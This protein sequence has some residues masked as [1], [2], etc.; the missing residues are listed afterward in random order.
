MFVDETS[1]SSSKLG[2]T[3]GRVNHR[4]VPPI[5][6]DELLAGNSL[7]TTSKR[8]LVTMSKRLPTPLDVVLNVAR[9]LTGSGAYDT[10]ASLAV[11]CKAGYTL[12]APILYTHVLVD[13]PRSHG[14]FDLTSLD[15]IDEDIL[16]IVALSQRLGIFFHPDNPARRLWLLSH[17]RRLTIRRFPNDAHSTRFRLSAKLLGRSRRHLFPEVREINLDQPALDCIRTFQPETYDTPRSPPFLEA[18]VGSSRPHTLRCIYAIVPSDQYVHACAASTNGAY[19][20]VSRLNQLRHD[21][22]T[23]LEVFEVHGAVHQVLPSLA[24]VEN[25]YIFAS[26]SLASDASATRTIAQ[27]TDTPQPGPSWTYRAW[28]CMTAVKNVAKGRNTSISATEGV[29]GVEPDAST[30]V[31][32]AIGAEVSSDTSETRDQ[33]DQRDQT[34]T[35]EDGEIGVGNTRWRFFNVSGH[36]EAVAKYES[37]EGAT[38]GEVS[39]LIRDCVERSLER[40]LHLPNRVGLLDRIEW[41][42][43]ARREERCKYVQ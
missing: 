27:D 33:R 37:D 34:V 4:S 16:V 43:R 18:L 29:N 5:S 2:S 7:V 23:S 3:T 20:F 8:P 14:L 15:G 6:P 22:W 32:S 19:N 13:G 36:I 24:G 42:E 25:R 39:G 26:H 40:D 1:S 10:L 41:V 38:P 21:G 12:L 30:S 35:R 17:I 31:A 9:H 28:Q 11:C